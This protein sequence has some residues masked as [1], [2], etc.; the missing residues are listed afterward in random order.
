VVAKTSKYLTKIPEPAVAMI[1]A[2]RRARAR[3]GNQQKQPGP[4][5]WRA[6]EEQRAQTIQEP[7]PQQARTNQLAVAQWQQKRKAP[8]Q[9]TKKEQARQTYAPAAC[10][11]ET[12]RV[13]ARDGPKTT[14][15]AGSTVAAN[16][17]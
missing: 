15:S 16:G 6:Q 7:D 11:N 4:A 5:H 9:P 13:W 14:A 8:Q 12:G 17:A 10:R 2:L 1:A 3:R